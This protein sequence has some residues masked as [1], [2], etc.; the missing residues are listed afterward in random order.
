MLVTSHQV[1]ILSIKKLP[2]ISN[3]ATLDSTRMPLPSHHVS[4][5]PLEIILTI[6]MEMRTMYLQLLFS[7]GVPPMED[8]LETTPGSTT[9]EIYSRYISQEILLSQSI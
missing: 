5:L 3:I 6:N 9:P 8:K 2:L 7:R 1:V 4:H